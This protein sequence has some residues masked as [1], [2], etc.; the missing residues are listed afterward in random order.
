MTNLTAD[1]GRFVSEL[2]LESIP[3]RGRAIAKTGF[4]D[5]YA[6]MVAG[7]RE[8]VVALVDRTLAGI[9]TDGG[10][11]LI[12][13]G[14]RRRVADAALV[15]GVA[16]HV[17]DYDD[18]S[19]DGHPSAVLVPAILAQAEASGTSGAE[20]LTAYVAGYEVWAELFRRED[21]HLHDKGWHPTAVLGAVAAAAACAK[22]RRL[23]P[24]K[25]ATAIA[26]AASMSAGLVSNFGTMTKSFQVGRAAQSGVI[27]ASLAD[28]GFTASLDAIEH[29][30][31]FLTALSPGGKPDRDSPAT[32]LGSEWQ[33]LHH[34]L[35]VKRYPVCYATH[36][37]I[38]G[39]LALAQKHDLKPAD[40]DSIH[41]S[42]GETQMLM[43]R[44]HRPQTGLEAK[45]SMH[46]AMASSIV[47]RNVGLSELTDEFVRKPEVQ[48]L[49]GRV[50][51]E[52]TSETMAE[53]SFAPFDAVVIRTTAGK[54]IESGPIERAKGSHQNPLS[55]DELRTK[56]ADCMAREL[57]EATT[58][59]VFE[60]FMG[61]ERLN[62]A[63]ELV[64]PRAGSLG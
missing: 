14:R 34:G 55:P 61:L 38:D 8:P 58:S 37:S 9:D 29:R 18:V 12:P 50:T 64:R 10:A 21:G 7:A 31:G 6:V 40:I 32:R 3:E 19:L 13:S 33:I 53:L 48:A 62:T 4:A 42:T 51:C 41:V 17:L 63:A 35:N 27:A 45:F 1:L 30:A 54:E 57:P 25:T 47:A 43:L 26:A 49:M 22:L 15:N 39:A 28:A 44:N 59:R 23:D 60:G 11:S 46:F 24:A 56:F 36:R 52:T 2:R 20:M 16:A 5:C